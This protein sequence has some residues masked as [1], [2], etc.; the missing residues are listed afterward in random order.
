MFLDR[1]MHFGKISGDQIKGRPLKKLSLLIDLCNEPESTRS[2][3][4]CDPNAVFLDRVIHIGGS[5]GY[6]VNGCSPKKLVSLVEV[7]Y[8]ALLKVQVL[9]YSMILI[10]SAWRVPRPS[11]PF[12]KIFEVR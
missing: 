7:P 2:K 4:Q 6:R 10:S 9:S 3:F 12:L 11:Y 1:F 8:E 5:L